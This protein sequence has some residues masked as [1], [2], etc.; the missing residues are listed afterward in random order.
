MIT[1]SGLPEIIR[2]DTGRYAI[3]PQYDRILKAIAIVVIAPSTS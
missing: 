1:Q 3:C 2:S